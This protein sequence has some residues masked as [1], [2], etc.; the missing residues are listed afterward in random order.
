MADVNQPMTDD[1]IRVR[2][3]SRYQFSWVAGGAG[4]PGTYTLRLVLD[5][6]AREDVLTLDPDNLQDLVE[7]TPRPL[8]RRRRVL[9]FGVTRSAPDGAVPIVVVLS[10][11][12][13][14]LVACTF[15]TAIASSQLASSDRRS[16][17]H[18]GAPELSITMA[19]GFEKTPSRQHGHLLPTMN[20]CGS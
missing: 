6:G 19:C 10:H 16:P 12:P 3:L 4:K 18:L 15:A 1:S 8:R 14:R 9:M 17:R 2:Q 7:N 20:C 5:Q 13:A 11:G